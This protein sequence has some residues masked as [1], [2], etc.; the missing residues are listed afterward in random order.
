MTREEFNTYLQSIGGLVN[1]WKS[2]VPPITDC[3]FMEHSSGWYEMEKQLIEDLIKLG[4]NK[5]VCQIKEKFGGLRFYIN[6]GSKEIHDRI[7]Q[8]ES[9]SY[10]I[11][12]ICGS[13]EHIGT[14]SGWITTMCE[15]CAIKEFKNKPE[16]KDFNRF[17][18]KKHIK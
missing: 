10:K 2:N 15:P 4:W 9:E 12:E 7:T 17:W 13:R 6:E 1:G 3:Y 8:A 18:T 11:C 14:T 16:P 5:E